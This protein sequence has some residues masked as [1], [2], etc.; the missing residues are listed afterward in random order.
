MRP[1]NFLL[2][3]QIFKETDLVSPFFI[4]IKK[5]ECLLYSHPPSFLFNAL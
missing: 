4:K 5:G 3:V 2:I 1:P